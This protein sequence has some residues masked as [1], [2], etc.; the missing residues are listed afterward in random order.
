MP[1]AR[2]ASPRGEEPDVP[3]HR[4]RIREQL[5]GPGVSDEELLLRFIMKGDRE[6]AAMRAAGPPKQ[7]FTA[8]VPLVT[9]ID[10][11]NK[12]KQVRFVNLQRG[13]D[14]LSLRNR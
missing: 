3:L 2:G 9:F 11:L 4:D 1:R 14:T 6:I 12:C 7:Y 13:S 8:E 10:T 5:S